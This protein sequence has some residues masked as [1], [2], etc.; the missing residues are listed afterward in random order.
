MKKIL[1]FA[2]SVGAFMSAVGSY[3]ML[4][5]ALLDKAKKVVDNSSRKAKI[6]IT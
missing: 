2:V 4:G 5:V 6:K 1:G 3:V